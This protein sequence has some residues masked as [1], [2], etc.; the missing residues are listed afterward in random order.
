MYKDSKYAYR[1]PIGTMEVVDNFPYQALKDYYEKW[2]RPDQQGII[3]V[4]DIDVDKVE[5]KIKKLFSPIEMP[6]NA[7]ER[8]YYPVPDNDEPL[9]ALAKDK[10]QQDE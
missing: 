3:V 1:L 8:V 6:A 9:I 5:E 4:G 7:A 2:Y 10:E